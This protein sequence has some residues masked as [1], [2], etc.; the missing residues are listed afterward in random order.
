MHL[1]GVSCQQFLVYV[2]FNVYAVCWQDQV[3]VCKHVI[4]HCAQLI[5]DV[6]RLVQSR[7]V[8]K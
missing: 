8:A 2:V 6:E 5:K 7:T 3:E 1:C 4:Q